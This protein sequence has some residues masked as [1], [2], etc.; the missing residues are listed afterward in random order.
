MIINKTTIAARHSS[1]FGFV[2]SL[3]LTALSIGALLVGGAKAGLCN[4][5]Y[6]L[7]GSGGSLVDITAY[8]VEYSDG[9]LWVV[10]YNGNPTFEITVDAAGDVLDRTGNK[11]GVVS[12]G[13]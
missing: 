11:R 2:R 8:V 10:D 5:E 4:T 9:S 12:E 7:F 1:R 13:V 6:Y 3:A